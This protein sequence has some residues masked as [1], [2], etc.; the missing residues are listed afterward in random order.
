[1]SIITESEF[2]LNDLIECTSVTFW[3]ERTPVF[4]SGQLIKYRE[5][6]KWDTSGY[7][8]LY[9]FPQKNYYVVFEQYTGS[10]DGCLGRYG[11][12]EED[13]E[14]LYMHV[15]RHN[16]AKSYVS[17]DKEEAERYY[18]NQAKYPWE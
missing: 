18:N 7:T 15:L 10:C 13:E 4:R 8:H 12:D 9:Y 3:N 1:M 11:F 16:A 6:G 17:E 14:K 5:W 2:L